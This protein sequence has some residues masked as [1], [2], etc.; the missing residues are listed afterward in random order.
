MPATG[1]NGIALPRCHAASV[2][3][4]QYSA[5]R[6][7]FAAA[8]YFLLLSIASAGTLS[9]ELRNGLPADGSVTRLDYLLSGLALQKEDGTWVESRAWVAFIP[10]AGATT[11]G[12]SIPDGNY[13]AIRF[14]VGV[15]PEVNAL[16]PNTIEPGDPLHPEVNKLHWGWQGDYIFLALEGHWNRPNGSTGGFSYH[17]ANNANLMKVELPVQFSGAGPAT[18]QL[19]LSADRILESG[20][21]I[22]EGESTHSREGDPLVAKLKTNVESAFQVVAVKTDLFQEAAASPAPAVSIPGTAPY[23]LELSKRLPRA[24][25]PAD[26]PLTVE[27]VEL[28]RRLFHESKLSKNN[29]QSCATCHGQPFAFSDARRLSAGAGGQAGRRNSMP[30]QNL[31]W[32]QSLFWDGRAKTLREQVLVPIEDA[33]EMNEKL[34]RVVGK[35]TSE[36][37]YPA[38]FDAAFGKGGITSDRIA[39]AL[40]QFLLTLVSQDSRF[41]RAARKLETLTEE[42]KRGLQLFVTEH[43]PARGLRGADCFHCHGGNLFTTGLF[44]NNG[45]V[46]PNG[47]GDLGREE[48][49]GDTRDRMKF[50]VPSL[51]NVAVTAPYMHDGRFATLEEVIEHYDRGV[52]RSDTLD[53]NLAKHPA[54]GLGLS[55]ADKRA[56]IA[57]LK[58]LTDES[59]IRPQTAKP[60][61]AQAQ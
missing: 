34:D 5:F 46:P 27:G 28:G 40:E 24:S 18:I 20:K 60:A 59:F 55:A 35:L 11:R 23:R 41:D 48:I 1:A 7:T 42:E 61:T 43:D 39:R 52:H 22:R 10:T 30:L 58:T 6:A 53:P 4:I 45:L 8:L 54:A 36:P 9:L 31:A 16:D 25:L 33:H 12:E 37:G 15:P 49:T 26:N 57:F 13:K 50:K 32:A 51:R 14:Q 29:V 3:G 21:L 56:L 17:I 47:K 19:S 38:Q 2:F 44:T